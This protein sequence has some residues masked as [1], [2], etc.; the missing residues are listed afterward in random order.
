[1]NFFI[2]AGTLTKAHHSMIAT[3]PTERVFAPVVHYE[4]IANKIS[5]FLGTPNYSQ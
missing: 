4:K 1:M 5:D 3:A 2:M